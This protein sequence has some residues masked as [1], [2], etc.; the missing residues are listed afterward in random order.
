MEKMVK[1]FLT[2]LRIILG[3]YF[4]FEGISKILVSGWTSKNYLLGSTWIFSDFFYW[5]ASSPTLVGIVDFLNI[6]GLILIG[7]SLFVGLYVRWA[8][9]FAA[10]LLFF[11]SADMTCG[12]DRS[13]RRRRK[14]WLSVVANC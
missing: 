12:L 2:L 8:S 9:L 3:W 10:I 7:I 1:Y 11:L 6:W 14:D 4:L 13:P 5:L